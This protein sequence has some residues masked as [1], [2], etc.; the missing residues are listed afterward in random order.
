MTGISNNSQITE[1]DQSQVFSG[2]HLHDYTEHSVE[3][4]LVKSEQSHENRENR[5]N[6]NAKSEQPPEMLKVI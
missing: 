1:N 4:S 3:H 2:P 6:K 5:D